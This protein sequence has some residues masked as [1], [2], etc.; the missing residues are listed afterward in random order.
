M[1]IDII[2]DNEELE[3]IQELNEI[4]N[5]QEVQT[6]KKAIYNE[7]ICCGCCA[8]CK[9]KNECN[10]YINY[11]EVKSYDYQKHY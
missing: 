2:W 11:Q 1:D 7:V 5:L 10:I 8:V 4:F 3:V 9:Y 6:M